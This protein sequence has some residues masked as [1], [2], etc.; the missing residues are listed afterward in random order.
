MHYFIRKIIVV[1]ISLAA[2]VVN[3]QEWPTKTTTIINPFSGGTT[4]DTLARVVADHLQ[5]KFDQPFVVASKPGAG[6]MIGTAAVAKAPA[7]GSV[8]GVSIA[9]PLVTNT[10]LY[11]SMAYDPFKDLVPLTLGVHQPCLLVVSKSLG[12]TT[13]Q[14]LVTI[15]KKNPGKYNY[16]YVGNGSLGHLVMAMLA[17]ESGTEIVPVMYPGAGQAIISIMAG[18][19]QMACLPAQGV[20]GQVQA[21]TVVPLAVSTAKRSTLLPKVPAL[22]ETY[23]EIVG[24]AW[25]GFVAPAKTPAVLVERMNKEIAAALRDPKIVKLLEQQFMEPVAGTSD[26]FRSFMKEELKRWTPVIDRNNISI[27]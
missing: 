13:V 21:G 5:K 11:K 16:A 25:I 18:D 15:L 3:A 17:N 24:S 10:L 14:E 19:V 1:S 8:I 9:G 27:D 26:E 6:G 4:T 7:D 12:I 22:R 20:I 2:G 23:P